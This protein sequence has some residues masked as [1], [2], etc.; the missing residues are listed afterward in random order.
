MKTLRW[1]QAESNSSK[2]PTRAMRI[3]KNATLRK[4]H[5]S[6]MFHFFITFCQWKVLIAARNIGYLCSDVIM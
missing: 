1:L 4:F 6:H 2:L 5:K 3:E